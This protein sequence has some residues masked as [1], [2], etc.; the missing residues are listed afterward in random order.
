M[1]VQI[2]WQ[3]H[4]TIRVSQVKGQ[5]KAPNEVQKELKE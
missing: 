4:F 1:E 2:N 3:E 5:K